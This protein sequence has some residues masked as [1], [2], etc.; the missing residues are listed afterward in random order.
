M[1]RPFMSQRKAL[2]RF[3]AL[4]LFDTFFSYSAFESSACF[5]LLD[6]TVFSDF[7]ELFDGAVVHFFRND[8]IQ[9]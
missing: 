3:F 9:I 5:S 6:L 8:R 1:F 4:E 7:E 2:Q